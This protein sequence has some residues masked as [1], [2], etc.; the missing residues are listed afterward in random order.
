MQGN[1]RVDQE[2]ASLPKEYENKGYTQTAVGSNLNFDDD[3]I[4]RL[5]VRSLSA[6]SC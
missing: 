1:A 5:V 6:P 2:K 3:K 4:F